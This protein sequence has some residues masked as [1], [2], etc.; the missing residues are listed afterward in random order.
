MINQ[1]RVKTVPRIRDQKEVWYMPQVK[2]WWFPIWTDMDIV[3]EIDVDMAI[4]FI[5]NRACEYKPEPSK[6][7]WTGTKNDLC[8]K[9]FTLIELLVVIAIVGI[10]LVA[11]FG[12]FT[13]N[14]TPEEIMSCDMYR[15]FT[16]KDIPARC[17]GYFGVSR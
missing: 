14:V 2:Y 11:A 12:L 10:M 7:M 17:F 6:I 8:K 4:D 1:Y 3:G 13:G 16:I 15:H 5:R 9:G